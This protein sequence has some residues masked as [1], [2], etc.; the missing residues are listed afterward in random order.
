MSPIEAAIEYTGG[1]A[2]VDYRTPL[3]SPPITGRRQLPRFHLVAAAIG[4]PAS[5]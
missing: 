1:P 4:R 2:A 3:G 5:Q